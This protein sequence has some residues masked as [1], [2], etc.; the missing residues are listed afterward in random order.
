M[1]MQGFS[2]YRMNTR[3]ELIARIVEARDVKTNPTIE[4]ESLGKLCTILDM[5]KLD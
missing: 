1:K 2:K 3:H 5:T 4:D